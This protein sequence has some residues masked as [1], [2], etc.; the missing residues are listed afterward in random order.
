MYTGSLVKSTA[1]AI[2]AAVAMYLSLGSPNAVRNAPLLVLLL[3]LSTVVFAY[4]S[5]AHFALWREI[6]S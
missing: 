4:L 1:S 2:A 5:I 3:R 6:L